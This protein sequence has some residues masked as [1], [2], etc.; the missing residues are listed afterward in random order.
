MVDSAGCSCWGHLFLFF[1]NATTNFKDLHWFHLLDLSM[2]GWIVLFLFWLTIKLYRPGWLVCAYLSHDL[3]PFWNIDELLKSW[4]VLSVWWHGCLRP[5]SAR[6]PAF[7][8]LCEESRF[9]W[10][11]F[12]FC[13]CL[14]GPHQRADGRM[15]SAEPLWG[16]TCILWLCFYD[17]LCHTLILSLILESTVASSSRTLILF[18]SQSINGNYISTLN[19]KHS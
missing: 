17:K 13:C 4:A 5:G 19:L 16:L 7:L 12:T 3:L 18:T 1:C 6:I 2:R 14:L 11:N 15:R 9:V 10:S 8:S